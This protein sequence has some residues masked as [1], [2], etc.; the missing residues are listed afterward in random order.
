MSSTEFYDGRDPRLAV[1]A[2]SPW[3]ATLWSS[4]GARILW[5]NPA[6]ATLFDAADATALTDK[7]FGP[8]D[9]H[10]RQVA[11][12]AGRL[13]PTGAVRLERLRGFGAAPGALATCACARLDF[14]GGGSG[15]L[16]VA[17]LSAGELQRLDRASRIPA[18]RP[19][20]PLPESAVRAEIAPAHQPDAAA[21]DRHA[22]D[23]E[24]P[25]ATGEA[26]VE[27]ALIDEVEQPSVMP[28]GDIHDEPSPFVEAVADEP[29]T[30]D[31]EPASATEAPAPR[32]TPVV[33]EL[34]P[35]LQTI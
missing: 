12:L 31:T 19:A 1:H 15:V 7:T 27:F 5:A 25:A 28:S 10:R 30:P 6:G 22:P 2:T 13:L 26:P 17:M 16:V 29:Q 14:S 4:E 9:P 3:P 34:P 32:D 23:Y 18:G 33:N 35:A 20:R 11:R 21:M 24:Q 8:A